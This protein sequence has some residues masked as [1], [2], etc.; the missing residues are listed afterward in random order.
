MPEQRPHRAR[1]AG[2][3]AA[4]A[5]AV[6]CASGCYRSHGLDAGAPADA[7]AADSSAG[8]CSFSFRDEEAGVVTCRVE[9]ES[10]SACF[11]VA[12]CVCGARLPEGTADEVAGC[13]DS[14]TLPRALA[15]LSD[16]CAFEEPARMAL[17]EALAEFV[18]WIGADLEASEGCAEIP[19]LLGPSSR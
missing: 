10:R 12:R 3:V 16:F 5:I 17:A 18:P 13:V 6:M 4:L 14:L 11:D 2:C 7:M 9:R 8:L 19:A 15:T 1:A